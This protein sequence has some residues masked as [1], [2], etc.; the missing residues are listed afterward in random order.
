[1]LGVAM[2]L[3][4]GIFGLKRTLHNPPK[5]RSLLRRHLALSGPPASVR[6][7]RKEGEQLFRDLSRTCGKSV[8]PTATAAHPKFNQVWR[9]RCGNSVNL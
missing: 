6:S 1:M 7:G 4:N 3:R 9:I 2:T 5:G 8:R